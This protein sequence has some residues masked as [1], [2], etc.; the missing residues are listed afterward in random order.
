MEI[1]VDVVIVGAGI[2]GLTTSLGLYRLGVESIVLEA[3]DSLRNTGFALTLWT[4]AWKALDAVG[5]GDSLRQ[6]HF[7]IQGA[8]V[9]SSISGLATSET[10]FHAKGNHEIRCVRRK[11]LLEALAKELPSGTIRYS[12]KVV[13]IEESGFFKL[14]HLSDGTILKTKTELQGNPATMKQFVFSK[15]E[16]LPTQLRA[17]IESTEPDGFISSRLTYRRPWELLWGNI[18]K[19]NVCVAGDAFHPMTPDIGQGGGAA[20]EDGV[21]LARCV[22]EALL[23]EPSEEAKEKGEEDK[24]Q[25]ERIEMG[26][27]K[28]AKERRWRAFELI[29]TSYFAGFVQQSEGKIMSFLREKFLASYL[30]GLLLKRADFNCGRLNFS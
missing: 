22:A 7:Q 6:Q 19:S 29:T 3:W 28:Y 25:H 23:K 4:N 11:K 1:A 8:I 24:E 14:V 18:S 20:L 21:V 5:V 2:A 26:L 30:R 12:S 10:S 13:C 16:K 9:V 15:L 27:N 17:V